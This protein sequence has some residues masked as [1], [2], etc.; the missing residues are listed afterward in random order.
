VEIDLNQFTALSGPGSLIKSKNEIYNDGLEVQVIISSG[1]ILKAETYEVKFRR[2]GLTASTFTAIA[3]EN[4]IHLPFFDGL[5]IDIQAPEAGLYIWAEYWDEFN[6][7]Y[8]PVTPK[9]NIT[10]QSHLFENV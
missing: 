3:S 4:S 5:D 10:T 7:D 2:I 9:V 8:Y 1:G 6:E